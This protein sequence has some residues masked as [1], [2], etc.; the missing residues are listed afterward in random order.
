[1]SDPTG[2]NVHH[3]RREPLEPEVAATSIEAIDSDDVPMTI[4]NRDTRR[5]VVM[6]ALR[7]LRTRV[8]I[9]AL[10]GAMVER[11]VRQA[12]RRPVTV[13]IAGA[14]VVS[15]MV[16]SSAFALASNDQPLAAPPVVVERVTLPPLPAV[17]HT[18]TAT[19]A[20]ERT[21]TLPPSTPPPSIIR[22]RPPPQ[23]QTPAPK[24]P[25]ARPTARPSARPSQKPPPA[26]S[27]P[28]IRVPETPPATPRQTEAPRPQSVTQPSPRPTQRANPAPSRTPEQTQTPDQTRTPEA[29]QT[30][31]PTPP[32][33]VPTTKACGVR[34]DLG[35]LLDLCVLG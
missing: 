34:V 10:L 14:T 3:F 13:A 21:I 26:T 35:P 15:T 24:P 9:P 1:M 4:V 16:V 33:E 12:R 8:L 11:L 20:V 30:P 32:P 29:P 28:E 7:R 5:T 31:K 19:S 2:D 23:V 17:T 25:Q 6:A 22:L 27:R 18:I